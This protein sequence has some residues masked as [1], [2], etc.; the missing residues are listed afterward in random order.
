MTD[1]GFYVGVLLI[2]DRIT[3][4]TYHY[5]VNKLQ[6]RLLAWKEHTFS[7]A[8]WLTY[9]KTVLSALPTYVMKTILLPIKIC[10]DSDTLVRNF[11]WGNKHELHSIHLLNW[12]KVSSLATMVGLGLN[13]LMNS[14]LPHLPR[15]AG[16]FFILR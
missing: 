14:I 10:K 1:L 2:R 7:M 8:R 11:L 15:S 6:A 9:A 16:N 3:P 12:S 5:V 4:N 13:L